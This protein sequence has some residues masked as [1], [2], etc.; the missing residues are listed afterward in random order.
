MAPKAVSFI[1]FEGTGDETL[2]EQGLS[3]CN[4]GMEMLHSLAGELF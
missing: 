4:R 3:D 1:P 2:K